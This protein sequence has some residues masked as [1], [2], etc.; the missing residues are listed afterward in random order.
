[1]IYF[2]I[3]PVHPINPHAKG[4]EELDMREFKA[5]LDSKGAE[6]STSPEFLPFYA[7]PYEKNP[8]VLPSSYYIRKTPSSNPYSP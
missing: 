5:Y 7:L 3:Y 8:K 1:M 6:F 4:I 2:D